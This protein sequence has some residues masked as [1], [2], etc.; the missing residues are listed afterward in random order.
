ME[1]VELD[2]DPIFI[3]VVKWVEG[4]LKDSN[5]LEHRPKLKQEIKEE[6]PS[7]DDQMDWDAIELAETQ[8]STP[9]PEPLDDQGEFKIAIHLSQILGSKNMGVGGRWLIP[10]FIAVTKFIQF[11]FTKFI[12]NLQ[13]IWIR[14][15]KIE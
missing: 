13:G 10:K 15:C 3:S 5:L 6:E 8:M 2:D 7:S 9:S 1:L 12:Q 11:K 4:V 14:L